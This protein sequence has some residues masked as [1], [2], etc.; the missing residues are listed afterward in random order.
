MKFQYISDIH[1]EFYDTNNT[2]SF[3]PNSYLHPIAPYLVLA[4]DIGIPELKSYRIF[5]EWCS[6]RWKHIF[7]VAGNHEYYTYRCST[8]SDM[9]TKQ[10]LIQEICSEFSN[11]H[12][13]N[14]DSFYLQEE[15][16]RILG[17]T[18]WSDIPE[19]KLGKAIA[20]MNDTRFIVE[21][22]NIFITPQR[23]SELHKEEKT[24]LENQIL[25]CQQNKEECLV[26]T[27]HLPSF[28][29]IHEKYKAHPLNV[30]FA[31]ECESLIHSPV[32]GWICGHSHTAMEITIHDV[33]C[34]LNPYGYPG[35]IVE[36][37]NKMSVL[38]I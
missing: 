16:I 4:G 12:F 8:K 19:A 5:L 28:S 29:L 3:F 6:S 24:W 38:E 7:L 18:L 35:E 14:C 11:I 30:C 13:L 33:P 32:K 27:H 9:K 25:Q 21:K 2:G 23:V 20:Y 37:R 1:L 34:R 26:I 31:S 10:A 22:D 36:T 15:G 17:C